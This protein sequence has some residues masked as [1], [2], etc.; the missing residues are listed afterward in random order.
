MPVFKYFPVQ[1][2]KPV[3]K[4][5]QELAT[6]NRDQIARWQHE[7]NGIATGWGLVT[8]SET[9]L[10]VLD[11][12][13]KAG[14]LETIATLP[15]PPTLSQQTQSGGYHFFFKYPQDGKR[16]PNRVGFK[17]GLDT[18]SDGGYVVV[19]NLDF[20]RPVAEA[21]QW[22]LESIRKSAVVEPHGPAAGV[23]AGL[24][25][26]T[27]DALLEEIRHA[28]PGEANVT[29]N[30][31]SFK[32]GQLVAGNN[33]DR[34]A[35]AHALLE[36]ALFRNIP[37]N[38]AIAT[39]DS[40]LNGGMQKPIVSPFGNSPPD[41]S[42][43][44][45]VPVP[46]RWTPKRLTLADLRNKS[47]L[48]K[49][50][51]FGDWSTEDI[52]ITTADGGTGKTTLKLFEAVQLA[53]GERFIGFDCKQRGRTLF[54]TG[55]DTAE[56]LAAML[57]EIIEQMGLSFDRPGD[58]EKI[59]V[60]LDSIVIKKDAD[61]CLVSKEKFTNFLVVNQDAVRK[62]EE[63]VLDFQPKMIVLDPI[64]SFW[65]SEASL[66]DMNKV[67]TKFAAHFVEKYHV[68]FEMI[69]HMGKS[70][71][72]TKDMS[73]FAGRG[74]SGLP[75]NSRVSR[76]MRR[77]DE[78][79][80]KSLTGRDLVQ[81]EDAIMCVV[82]KFTDGTPIYNKPFLIIRMGYLFRREM[83][84]KSAENEVKN[85]LEDTERIF[86]WIKEERIAGR[87]PTKSALEYKFQNTSEPIGLDRI[88]RALGQLGYEGFL[89]EK[90]RTVANP[91]ETQTEKV[92]AIFNEANEEI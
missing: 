58:S 22:L 74:G 63:A 38:E 9:G 48:R 8:G 69:N 43:I 52:H 66:N 5:W 87:Y 34:T 90:V 31:S 25:A 54:I 75:S 37:R 57:G 33:Y 92:Y 55:E 77:V 64:S 67:V 59:Q 47:K 85:S 28:A 68:C 18:R 45:S 78:T 21:P 14:G 1:G 41:T 51:L 79:E 89:G 50:Q 60:I 73:Q 20:G 56:K 11:V 65:G 27:W 62:L 2:K 91:D 7:F 76:V 36:A 71:S 23:E 10:L 12:D 46:E 29:L 72:Q 61:L 88:K 81:G 19:Y 39:I 40:G 30:A 16:Y 80:F 53:L 13:K 49:P 44:P 82:N 15:V 32:A 70:S 6:D 84:S 24:A 17:P 35:V 4:N 83:L 26:R 86:G 42:N 3:V